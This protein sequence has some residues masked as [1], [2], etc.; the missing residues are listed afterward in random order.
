VGPIDRYWET[1]DHWREEIGKPRLRAVVDLFYGDPDFRHAYERCP[2]SVRGHHAALGG[3]LKHTA[4]VAAIGRT[5][6]RTSGAD[7]EIVLAGALLH[8]IGK[9]ES[10]RWDGLFDYTTVGRLVGHVTLGALMLDRRLRE[11]AAPA[12]TDAE[13]DILLHLLL[14]HHGQ[15]ELGSPVTPMT[16]EAEVLHWADISS[17]STASVAEVLS[18]GGN[19]PAGDVSTRQ[20]RLDGRRLIRVESDWGA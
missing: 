7:P 2:G 8:D 5:L 20:W 4:E 13:R 3:L 6:A 12:C 15:L 16:L 10:Y 9:T 17:A 14:S 18:D 11:A 1:L 19:F